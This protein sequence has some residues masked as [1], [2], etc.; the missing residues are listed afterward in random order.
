MITCSQD[1]VQ[2]PTYL[3]Y[4]HETHYHCTSQD[5]TA[6]CNNSIGIDE[7]K[8]SVG[9]D[10]DCQENQTTQIGGNNDILGIIKPLDFDIT[11]FQSKN[12]CQ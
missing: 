12:D 11:G 4:E 1:A 7:V 5:E 3:W 9:H 10:D 8:G 2:I 6:T